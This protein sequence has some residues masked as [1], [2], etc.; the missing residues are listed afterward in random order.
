MYALVDCNSF[1]VSCERLFEPGL[2]NR[3][4]VVLS[5]NDGCV[6]SLSKEAKGLGIKMGAPIYKCRP[7][8]ESAGGTIF[9]SNYTLYGDLSSRVMNTLSTFAPEIEIYSI[10][11]A[12]LNLKGIKEPLLYYGKSIKKR[13]EQ[14]TGIPVSV[15]IA[16]TKTLAKAASRHAKNNNGVS[17]LNTEKEIVRF[18]AEF[19]VSDIWGIGR[20][21]SGLLRKH[22]INTALK[23]IEK[24]DTWIKKKLTIA[25]LKMIYELRGKECLNLETDIP[26]KKTIC[27]SRSFG[28]L[29]TEKNELM[30]AISQYASRAAQKLREQ[31]CSAS[32]LTLF[33][34]TNPFKDGPQYSNAATAVFNT[35]E[36]YTPAFIKAAGSLLNRI[37]KPGYKYKKAGIILADIIPDSSKQYD[38]FSSY[39][40]IE[41]QEKISRVMDSINARYGR[42]TINI[43]TGG[44][45]N[46]W[47][48]RREYL[49]PAYTT[50]FKQLKVIK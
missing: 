45:N 4:V 26:P 46:D 25:G 8:I 49:S 5:N 17:I 3:P 23:L 39:D 9:S 10:D 12:F 38:L 30:Q 20:Q 50:D 22:G 42:N 15:G 47:E 44:F 35:A 21:Y 36:N 34:A 28:K 40:N 1:Y 6:I 27:S 33:I 16:P 13:V 31:R 19:D 11:E 29:I 7:L 2:K 43:C 48:M 24:N 37:Y 32:A 18:L 41:K 14:Y